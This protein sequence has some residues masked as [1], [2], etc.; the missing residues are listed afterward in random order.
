MPEASGEY[1]F[2]P[3]AAKAAAAAKEKPIRDK[4]GTKQSGFVTAEENRPPRECGNCRWM[5]ESPPCCTHEQV[6]S[7]PEL[8]DRR[9]PDGNIAVALR[10]CCDM[11]QN[12][13]WEGVPAR[14]GEK[15]NS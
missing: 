11:F 10:D 1:R 14:L 7:D 5:E 3:Q 13:R 2:N 4:D 8:K 15:D 9:L 12:T 6:R